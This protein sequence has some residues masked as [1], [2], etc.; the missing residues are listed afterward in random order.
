MKLFK[1]IFIVLLLSF[2][3][4]FEGAAQ[5]ISK[6][7]TTSASFLRIPVGA[8]GSAMGNAISA[9]VTDASAMYWNPGG[10]AALE[11][12]EL[13]VE[14][15]DWFVDVNHNYLGAAY[16]LSNN[17]GV[18]GVNVTTLSMGEMEETTYDN[19]EGT[20]RTFNAYSM[21][22]GASYS[23]Y[24]LDVFSIGA[25]VKFIQEKIMN[26]SASS[27]AIDIGTVYETPFDGILFGVSVSNFG[28]KMRMDGEDLI[29][30]T[31]QDEQGGGEYEPDAKLYTDE[32]NLPLMLRVGLAWDAYESQNFDATLT[33]EGNSPNDNVQSVS[34]GTEL[35]FLDDLLFLRGG[36]PY[37]GRE[38][39]MYKFSV[40]A[41]V[42]YDIS[43]QFGVNV[44]YSYM[45]H[46][47][48]NNISRISLKM[49]F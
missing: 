46:E 29:V 22:V 38:D 28:Q 9:S 24:L 31:D 37:L 20:G 18:F 32:F 49:Q 34:V 2:V 30:S 17:R 16:P 23:R 12:P 1:S 7:G 19:P 48:L 3:F 43:D 44:G 21:A 11:R 13:L 35:S 45:S 14:Y 25:N 42:D 39:R 36:L 5:S 15:A 26:S 10:L 33:V 40:G 6:T 41:G 47:Y 4:P 27:V 8:R